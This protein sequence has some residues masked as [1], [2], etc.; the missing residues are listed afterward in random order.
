MAVATPAH[1]GTGA[2]AYFLPT[3]NEWY[4]AAYYSGGG[5]N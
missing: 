5:T 2:P 4:K 1:S 3:E